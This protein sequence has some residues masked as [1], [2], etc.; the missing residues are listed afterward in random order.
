MLS[1]LQ[2]IQTARERYRQEG[3]DGPWCRGRWSFAEIIRDSFH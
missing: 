3:K 2:A 1:T